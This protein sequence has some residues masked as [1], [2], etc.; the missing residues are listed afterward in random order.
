MGLE[1]AGLTRWLA[2]RKLSG[3]PAPIS[4]FGQVLAVL[5]NISMVR[6]ELAFDRGYDAVDLRSEPGNATN[7]GERQVET[8][9]RVHHRHV[10]RCGGRAFLLK[11]VDV[12]IDVVFAPIG[13]TVDE[14]GIAVIG[15]DHGS[16]GR[17]QAVERFVRQAMRMHRL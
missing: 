16:I 2:C 9:D 5:L 8:I 15:E 3:T 13:E 11:A 17:E 6:F 10:E 1:A 12:E 4:D 14:I 7:G